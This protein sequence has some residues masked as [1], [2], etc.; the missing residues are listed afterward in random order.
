[1]SSAPDLTIC[2]ECGQGAKL[3]GGKAI[4]PHRA[5]LHS[6]RYWRCDCG[7]Y[8]GCHGDTTNPLGYPAGPA[9]RRARSEAHAAFDPLWKREGMKRS[10]AYQW[11]AA[12][13][14]LPPHATHISWMDAATARRVVLAVSARKSEVAPTRAP[15]DHV[16]GEISILGGVRWKLRSREPGCAEWEAI[17]P[18]EVTP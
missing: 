9:T 5:D 11:L 12:A 6:K 10:A 15:A 16:V 7:A 8:V 17:G 3:V 13:L 18:V 1:M 4:Y 14:G 2:M